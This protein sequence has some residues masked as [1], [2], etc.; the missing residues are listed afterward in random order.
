MSK[1]AINVFAAV[2]QQ[3]GKLLLCQRALDKRYGGLW[4]FPGGK[5][6]PGE[7]FFQAAK[8][9]LAEELNVDV[10]SLG[11]HYLSVEDPGSNFVISFWETKIA[12]T[13]KPNEHNNI[14]WVPLQD[15]LSYD[16]AVNDRIFCQHYQKNW[17]SEMAFINNVEYRRAE[18][19]DTY[20]GQRQ[21]GI[22]TPAKFPFIF[23][24]TA[25]SGEEYGYLDRFQSDRTYWYTGEGQI[26]NQQMIRGNR[27]IRDSEQNDET[28]HLF[29]YVRTGIVRYVG[30]LI[31]TGHHQS[32][33]PDVN[34][35]LRKV[36]VFELKKS[37]L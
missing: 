7:T 24:F 9:E 31:Y 13:L 19:H 10:L 30:E 33:A 16:L 32:D 17:R 4:E 18:L 25:K 1:N 14:A 3:N 2:I 37:D 8:R 21:G 20:G 36:I 22:S 15:L 29:E 12:G 23:I 26:G 11:I 27:A 5:L 6:E 35:D 28:I 34:G